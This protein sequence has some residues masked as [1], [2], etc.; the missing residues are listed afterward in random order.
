MDSLITTFHIDWKIVI[1]QVINFGIVFA[2]LYFFALKPLS[3]LMKEREDIIS[4]AIGTTFQEYGYFDSSF[5]TYHE[6]Y[7]LYPSYLWGN[8][9]QDK[10]NKLFNSDLTIYE[11]YH[12]K[13]KKLRSN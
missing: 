11:K 10:I 5:S 3:K 7:W 2:V 12:N 9:F 8:Q 6:G 1:A 13:L 4:K